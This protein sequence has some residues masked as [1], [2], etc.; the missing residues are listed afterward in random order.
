[1][2][3]PDDQV[4]DGARVP[5]KGDV[6]AAKYRVE[7]I[8]G[9]GGMGV[10]A[11][12]R[13]LALNERVALKFLVPRQGRE[14]PS[15]TQIARFFREAQL[16][17]RIKS[18]HV[19]RVIDVGTLE[20]GVPFMVL[21]LLEG[22]DLNQMSR[23]RGPIPPA[24][25]VGYVLQ[26]C[27]AIAEAHALGIIHRDLKPANLFVARQHDGTQI[28]K[29]L[30]FGISKLVGE[31]RAETDTSLTSEADILGS[32]AYMAPEQIKN[33]KAVD[34]R[35]DVWS[36][37]AILYRLLT[38]E[39]AFPAQTPQ[40]VLAQV[41]ISAP[42]PPRAIRPEIPPALEALV[43]RCLEKEP[44]SRIGRVDELAVAL[45]R[46][47]SP[48]A[49]RPPMDSG[50]FTVAETKVQS[51]PHA[52]GPALPFKMGPQAAPY[53]APPAAAPFAAQQPGYPAP[54]YAM[55]I[56]AEQSYPP[57][58]AGVPLM[59]PPPYA[60]P[61]PA[62]VAARP[63]A[64]PDTTTMRPQAVPASGGRQRTLA[65]IGLV[66]IGSAVSVVIAIVLLGRSQPLTMGPQA[67]PNPAPPASALA[68]TASA[69]S[70][71][72]PPIVTAQPTASAEP[73]ASASAPPPPAAS[74]ASTAAPNKSK[75]GAKKVDVLEDRL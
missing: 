28:V 75:K 64:F 30:D 33:P 22:S 15:E 62:P 6:V 54:P 2:T 1:M 23:D 53:P 47:L 43:L 3:S 21:E 67:A 52:P 18:P 35:V 55:P 68:L 41:L 10:V 16:A 44:D 58:P 65:T 36:L 12:A 59:A 69:S 32:P 63:Q 42:I 73:T 29:V 25:A 39:P 60:A 71:P 57:L 49:G 74:A 48:E 24:E 20:T 11:A 45:K 8:I 5:R 56:P 31:A 7:R 34:G 9:S 26:A 50:G 51:V 14:S 66:V 61:H 27:E 72:A 37:G 70:A 13:H 40:Q 38:G 17:A 19:A 4:S 46:S